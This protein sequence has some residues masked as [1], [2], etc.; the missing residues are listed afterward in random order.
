M[1]TCTCHDLESSEFLIIL[2]YQDSL[3]SPIMNKRGAEYIG[4][5]W[6]LSGETMV[7]LL[8]E[9]MHYQCHNYR[10]KIGHTGNGAFISKY[11]ACPIHHAIKLTEPVSYEYH[12]V[13]G[14]PHDVFTNLPIPEHPAYYPE[15]MEKYQRDTKGRQS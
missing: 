12:K 4:N 1:L 14:I 15:T 2:H 8:C 11:I 3:G 9:E 7:Y 5:T 10:A 6:P 13:N